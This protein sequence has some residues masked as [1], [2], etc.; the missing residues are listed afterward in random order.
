MKLRNKTNLEICDTKFATKCRKWEA[1]KRRW[2]VT[3]DA[4]N[5]GQKDL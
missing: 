2:C 3:T 4:L 5:Y 1:N